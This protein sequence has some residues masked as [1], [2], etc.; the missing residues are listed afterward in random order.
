MLK[1][2]RTLTA[3]VD[4]C[5][6][7]SNC[8]SKRRQ[9]LGLVQRDQ[10]TDQSSNRGQRSGSSNQTTL[11][12]AR[13]SQLVTS[14][15]P[16]G[17]RKSDK[18]CRPSVTAPVIARVDSVSRA[19]GFWDASAIRCRFYLQECDECWFFRSGTSFRHVFIRANFAII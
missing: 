9:Q 10:A 2:L 8:A 1:K 11:R 13:I 16:M 14:G 4:D 7:G 3:S 18:R 19:D 12:F 15:F 17:K 6:R 5:P